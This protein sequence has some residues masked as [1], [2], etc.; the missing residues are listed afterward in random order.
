[1]SEYY[2]NKKQSDDAQVYCKPCNTESNRRWQVA[3]PDK[4]KKS[5]RRWQAKNMTPTYVTWYALLSRCRNP[6]RGNY[7][8]YGG[9][10]ITVC[11]R[12]D[13]WKGGSFANFLADMG[14][15]PEG[16]SID[17]IDNEGNYEPGNCRWATT[18]EQRVNQRNEIPE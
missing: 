5:V 18:A 2:K 7:P 10:G 9:R 15:R 11:E 14:E 6:K 8:R 17:R 4:F 1:M 12:W 13:T 16:L 3:N